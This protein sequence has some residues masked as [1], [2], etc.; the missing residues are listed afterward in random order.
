M[1]S[2]VELEDVSFVFFCAGGWSEKSLGGTGAEVRSEE[3]SMDGFTQSGESSQFL[4]ERGCE[5]FGREGWAVEASF[6]L[7]FS[8]EGVR[9]D[10]SITNF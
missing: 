4:V 7:V 6:E 9:T 1:F 3:K 8:L 5:V 2:R 10:S